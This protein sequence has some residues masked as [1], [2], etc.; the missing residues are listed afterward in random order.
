MRLEH[1]LHNEK[2]CD[3]LFNNM[4]GEFND[5]VVTTAFYACIHFVE[6]KTFP[7]EIGG[8]FFTDFEGY[9]SHRHFEKG[10][11]RSKHSLKAQLVGEEMPKMRKR[12][13]WL[14]ANSM[15][16]RYANHEVPENDAKTA[17]RLMKAIKQACLGHA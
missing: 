2:L 11:K 1:G 14:K 6:H 9:C 12:Y 5:W 10:D 8:M 4:Q 7:R 16:A 15:K 3:H 17:H 13:E